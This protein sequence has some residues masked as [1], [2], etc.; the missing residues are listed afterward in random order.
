MVTLSLWFKIISC[1]V[2][3]HLLLPDWALGD[4]WPFPNTRRILE[5]WKPAFTEV[6]RKVLSQP[7]A[8]CGEES[9]GWLSCGGRRKEPTAPWRDCTAGQPALGCVS[10]EF[11]SQIPH[12]FPAVLSIEGWEPGAEDSCTG[13]PTWAGRWWG[14]RGFPGEQSQ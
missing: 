4:L 7:W 11:Y 3:I 5:G 10:F 8:G 9:E 2:G 14:S 12:C 1:H 6:D 13:Q